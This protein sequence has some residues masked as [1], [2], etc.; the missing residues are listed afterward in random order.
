MTSTNEGEGAHGNMDVVSTSRPV[1]IFS[2]SADKD[3]DNL[4]KQIICR[5]RQIEKSPTKVF[6][7]DNFSHQ[8]MQLSPVSN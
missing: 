2:V 6:G 4:Q 7:F 8:R 3:A 1:E 5:Y